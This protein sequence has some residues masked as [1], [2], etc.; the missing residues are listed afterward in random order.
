MGPTIPISLKMQ[1]LIFNI[2]SHPALEYD[3]NYI[4][5]NEF[6]I[7]RVNYF[8][9]D[10]IVAIDDM[11]G[12]IKKGNNVVIELSSV[13]PLFDPDIINSQ[14]DLLKKNQDC[15]IKS[16]GHI[17]GSA[18]ERVY[19]SNSSTDQAMYIK[20]DKQQIYNSQLN[21]NKLKRQKHFKD[22]LKIHERFYEFTLEDFF[23]YI[24]I[25]KGY[26]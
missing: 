23:T 5:V 7:K 6:I 12:L 17:P 3:D 26:Q 13:N 4:T 18:P 8:F 25:G 21:L 20:S 1:N 22:F 19:Y 15:T 14:I 24:G 2:I 11:D 16:K 9:P 10:A